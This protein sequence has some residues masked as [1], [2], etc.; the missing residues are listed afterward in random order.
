LFDI[1]I[2]SAWL[3]VVKRFFERS[4]EASFA[5]KDY[6]A[7]KVDAAEPAPRFWTDVKAYEPYFAARRER[8][9]YELRLKAK[10]T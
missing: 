7:G 2:V 1:T 8:W 9:E 4:V 6:P 3:V 5:G 10:R